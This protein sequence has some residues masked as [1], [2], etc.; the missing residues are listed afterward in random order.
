VSVGDG[1]EFPVG[2]G[3]SVGQLVDDVAGHDVLGEDVLS[4]LVKDVQLLKV[5]VKTKPFYL[6]HRR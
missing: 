1:E 2:R 4:E 5:S 6:C 3:L